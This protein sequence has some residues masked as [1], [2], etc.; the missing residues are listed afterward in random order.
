M[1]GLT[2]AQL[3][4]LTYLRQHHAQHGTYPSYRTIADH[5]NL[6]SISGVTR[7]MD[8]LEER[9]A[10]RGRIRHKPGAYEIVSE[11]E[12]RSVLVASYLWPTLVQ[13]SI[14]EQ[15]PLE[16]A[17]NHFIRDGLRSA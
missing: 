1:I 5:L 15:T 12:S 2:Q 7:L 4:L 14:A 13:Y 17:V 6:K 3:N 8:G 16:T 9:G 11:G 10:I